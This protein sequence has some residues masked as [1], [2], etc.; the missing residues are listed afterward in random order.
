[1]LSS[2]LVSSVVSSK[3][4]VPNSEGE[5][6]IEII[7]ISSFAIDPIGSSG[8]MKGN[9]MFSNDNL[10]LSILN[11][12]DKFDPKTTLQSSVFSPQQVTS[13][14]KKPAEKS[15]PCRA[16]VA[17]LC[18]HGELN[19]GSRLHCLGL[20]SREISAPC[21][22]SIENAV[23]FTCSFEISIFCDS[24]NTVEKSV[25]QCLEEKME[26]NEQMFAPGCVDSM[27]ASRSVIEN[28][29]SKDF[30]NIHLDQFLIKSDSLNFGKYF[31]ILGICVVLYFL[32][33]LVN[34]GETQITSSPLVSSVVFLK[35]LVGKWGINHAFTHSKREDF[36]LLKF[37]KKNDTS[38]TLETSEED[39]ENRG[40]LK[41]DKS[42][43][44][45]N[46]Y[47]SM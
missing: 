22:K 21:L 5:M 40:I 44:S 23:P 28:L 4:K 1:L 2:P 9:D 18:N 3:P 16:D 33:N 29:N 38:S 31:L 24:S 13:N 11:E 42:H 27:K 47:G 6:Q 7:P 34:S 17:R 12:I 15:H 8:F 30:K 45:L 25:L 10:M 37:T 14:L 36:Q 26:K 39:L 32:F 41:R 19:S 46:S 43:G 20:H 35:G